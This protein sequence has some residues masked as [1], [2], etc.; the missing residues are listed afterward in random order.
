MIVCNFYDKGL[1]VLLYRDLI[2]LDGCTVD[3]NGTRNQFMTYLLIVDLL[4]QLI[5]DLDMLE[6]HAIRCQL[7][8]PVNRMRFRMIGTV[9]SHQH[10]A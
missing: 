10:A 8:R 4:V 9:L 2:I 3:L 5:P 7:D 1:A 6:A